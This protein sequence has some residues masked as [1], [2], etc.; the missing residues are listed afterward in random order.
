ML[1]QTVLILV[2]LLLFS[3]PVSQA[4]GFGVSLSALP[5][6]VAALFGFARQ[7][8]GRPF[9]W[10]PRVPGGKVL[11]A[12]FAAILGVFLLD[13]GYE[14][15]IEYITG[16]PMPDQMIISWLSVGGQS[17]PWLAFVGIAMAAPAAEEILF[18]GL[19]FGATESRLPTKW[20]I[21]VTA[22]VF[23]GAHLQPIYFVPIFAVGLMLGW[24][25]Q[26]SG[27]LGLPIVVHCLNNCVAL[28]IAMNHSA[29]RL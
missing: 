4:L 14:W 19:L 13:F 25:R 20:T 18:R 23:S 3:W 5:L 24:A 9:S 6:I 15:M 29:S 22:A 11:L 26:K 1:G 17:R 12:V 28:L 8:W 7:P 2:P 21:V 16:K 10:P 27:G